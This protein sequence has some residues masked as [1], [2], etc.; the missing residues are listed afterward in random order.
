MRGET[1]D[2]SD[3]CEYDWFEWLHYRDTESS[4]SEDTKIL[5][6]YLGPSKSIGPEMCCHIL[7][8]NGRV[9]QRSTIGRL[10][11]AEMESDVIKKQ[12]LDFMAA[13]FNGPL[14]PSLTNGDFEGDVD[15]DTP[16]YEPY[17][18]DSGDK[19]RMP[20]ADT[21]TVDAYEKYIGAQLWMPL[22]DSMAEAKV[23]GR[24]KDEDGNPV[25]TSH[26]NPLQDTRVYEV[27][28]DDG[29]IAK[30]SA[31]LIATAMFAQV[32]DEGRSHQILD[33]IVNHRRTK[34]SISKEEAFVTIQGKKHPVR[35]T[36]GWELCI[37]WK[38][39]DTSWEKLKDL[40]EANPIET[41]E[42]AVSK[43]IS[44]E[45]AFN[46]WAPYTLKKRDFIILAV[47]ARF[48]RRDYKFGIKVPANIPEACKLDLENGDDMWERSVEKEMKNVRV[49]FKVLDDATRVPVGYQ[50][51]PCMLI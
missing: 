19:P 17:G 36:K 48:V 15:S 9:I 22:R 4:Y 29:S 7:K 46:W 14:G 39:G 50:R 18:D 13:I 49:A 41:V 38:N 33:K 45:P 2:I 10:T 31:N 23:V 34:E 51:I 16:S 26:S 24:A 30:Y 44:E 35:T 5:V 25:G 28:F 3:I 37:L 27:A 40:K 21:F 20:V 32:D 6:R 1:A 12:K 8:A 11:P 42:Y 43:G 47:R